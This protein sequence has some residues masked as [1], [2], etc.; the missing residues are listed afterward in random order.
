LAV[1]SLP[2]YFRLIGDGNFNPEQLVGYELGLRT[3]VRNIAFSINAFYNRYNGLLSVENA[4]PAPELEPAPAH[5]VLPLWFRNGIDAQ[6]KGM[7]VSA[8]WDP[9]SWFRLRPSYSYVRLDAGRAPNSNDAST[10]KQL[11]GDTP[12]HKGVVTAAFTAPHSIT[13]DLTYR[14]VS[15][16][17]D[18]RVPAYSSADVR[19]AK[20]LTPSLQLAAT[21][22]NLLRPSHAE[23]GGLPGGIV[24]I[25]RSFF[26]SLTWSQ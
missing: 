23:Y 11:E 9:A 7:E 22:Q 3:Y 10:V 17:P 5:F 6:T 12:Q 24:E 26:L 19:V 16:I 25:R 8:L 14:Y 2:L 1:P 15:G 21:G 20:R 4:P 18:Q 13:A